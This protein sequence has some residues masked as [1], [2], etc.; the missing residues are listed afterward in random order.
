MTARGRKYFVLA[1]WLA[2]AF[3]FV[4]ATLP[5]PPTLSGQPSDKVQHVIA[6]SVLTGLAF[7]ALPWKRRLLIVLG[8]IAFG[9]LIEIV[10]LIPALH[11]ESDWMD[12]LADSAAVL[13]VASLAHFARRSRTRGL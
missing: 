6:F 2:A 5:Q 10:Q 4:M 8:L 7:T 11:R 13:V 9:A 3:A 1:F 12:L